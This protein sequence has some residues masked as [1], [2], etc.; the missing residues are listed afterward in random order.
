MNIVEE[1]NEW[2]NINERSQAYLARKSGVTPEHIC[3]ILKGK[4]ERVREETIEKI[5]VVIK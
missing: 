1:I 3:R 5:L 2:L 4:T